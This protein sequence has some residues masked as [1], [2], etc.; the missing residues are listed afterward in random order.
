[1]EQRR[2]RVQ[3]HA[4]IFVGVVVHLG[5]RVPQLVT[6]RRIPVRQVEIEFADVQI[7]GEVLRVQ[8]GLQREFQ[9]FQF[10]TTP[11]RIETPAQ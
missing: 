7:F 4:W 8:F 10:P 5:R 3:L 11:V 2:R 9:I 1:M 6:R